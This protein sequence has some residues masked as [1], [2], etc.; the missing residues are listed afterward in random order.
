MVFRS[1][2]LIQSEWTITI[3]ISFLTERKPDA[4]TERK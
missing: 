3:N 1:G 4:V 2:A